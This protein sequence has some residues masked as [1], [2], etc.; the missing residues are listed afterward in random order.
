MSHSD[1]Y[2]NAITSSSGQVNVIRVCRYTAIS[3]GDV[4]SYIFTDTVDTLASTVRAC[5]TES[6]TMTR[7]KIWLHAV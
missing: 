1:T 2:R 4:G 7:G 5:K 6:K 3:P